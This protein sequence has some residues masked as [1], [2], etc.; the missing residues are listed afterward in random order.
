MFKSRTHRK[1]RDVCATHRPKRQPSVSS[2][3]HSALPLASP[4]RLRV[5]QPESFSGCE[6]DAFGWEHKQAATE[7]C[8]KAKQRGC[9][10]A[11]V[12]SFEFD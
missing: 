2:V 8:T 7:T 9:V 12:G 5:L 6:V 4:A 1:I 3:G 10:R 11:P